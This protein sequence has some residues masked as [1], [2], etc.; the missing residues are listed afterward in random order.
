MCGGTG[1]LR[2]W[3]P[4]GFGLSPRVR[5]NPPFD[6][7]SEARYRSIP[8][9][10]GE[11]PTATQGRGVTRVYPRVCGGTNTSVLY[12]IPSPGLSPRVRGNRPGSAP[13][14]LAEGSIPACA[15]EPYSRPTIFLWNTVYPPRVRGNPR[16]GVTQ[17]HRAGSIPACAGEPP[18]IWPSGSGV[19]VYPRVCG[20]TKGPFR[21]YKV[22]RGLSPRV[23]GNPGVIPTRLP[24]YRSIPACAG[25]PLC[26]HILRQTFPV[27]PRVCGGTDIPTVSGRREKWVYP[28]VC[29]GTSPGRRTARCPPGLSPRVRGNHGL[30][31]CYSLNFRSIPACAGEPT[32]LTELSTVMRVYPRVC[33]GTV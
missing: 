21:T 22:S 23:R 31:T 3:T 32:I 20:G 30:N 26:P 15:G 8:A 33:G 12:N 1:R 11:P 19:T 14:A 29:G 18:V 5:G 10:A 4:T 13:V 6:G 7:E 27:Y 9:C 25:E 24:A 16:R 2:Y 17:I 28:R